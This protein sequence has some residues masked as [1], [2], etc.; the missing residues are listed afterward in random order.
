[1]LEAKK[2]ADS[3]FRQ[4]RSALDDRTILIGIQDGGSVVLDYLINQLDCDVIAASVDVSFHSDDFEISGVAKSKQSTSIDVDING[5]HVILVDDVVQSGRTARAAVNELFD[6]GRPQ[7]V[8]LA[9]L[10]DRGG[11]ELPIEPQFVGGLVEIPKDQKIEVRLDES[12]G[13]V[14]DVD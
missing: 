9:V 1:M 14:I 13:L 6:F 10:V 3:L 11:R 8:R 4:V 5:R 12:G 2:L 7:T